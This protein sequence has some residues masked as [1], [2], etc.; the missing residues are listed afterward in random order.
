MDSRRAS[1]LCFTIVQMPLLYEEQTQ[2]EKIE[3][4]KR[5]DTGNNRAE[6]P[7]S[8]SLFNGRTL[9]MMGPCNFVRIAAVLEG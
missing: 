2:D 4:A 9:E 1:N 8:S 6:G 7:A 3:G 5:R